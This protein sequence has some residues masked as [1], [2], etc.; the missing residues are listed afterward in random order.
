MLFRSKKE[1][2][3]SSV[4][5]IL[6][7]EYFDNEEN[8]KTK[9]KVMDYPV[10]ESLTA[11]FPYKNIGSIVIGIAKVYPAFDKYIKANNLEATESLEIYSKK[12]NK[13]FFSMPVKK[14]QGVN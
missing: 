7:N 2:L 4:G 12:E 14:K 8:I 13:I 3:R 5:C 1:N 9:F 6:E 11:E 10:T